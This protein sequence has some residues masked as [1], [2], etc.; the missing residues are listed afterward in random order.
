MSTSPELE[1]QNVA[2][3]GSVVASMTLL[4]RISGFVRDMM[5][6]NF[7]GAGAVTD[8][9]F[10]AFRI[11][12]FFRRLFAEG[13]FNQAFVPVLARYRDGSRSELVAFVRVMTGNLGLT[14]LIVVL[15][16]ILAAPGLVLVF[17]PGFWT[18]PE[19]FVLAR[20]MVE[21]TFP[22][23]GFI[24]MTAF[25]GAIL[26]THHRY[27]VPAFTPVLLNLSLI[28][29]MLFAAGA[30]AEPVF[31][32]AWGVL[33][34][35]VAQFL[36][37]LPALKTLGLIVAPQV[38][39]EHAGARRVGKLLVPAV[40]AA[41]V[42]QINALID[43]MLA[44][45]LLTGSISWL[46]YSDRLL[47]LPVGLVAV[48]LGTVLLPNLSRLDSEA[49]LTGF[50]ATLDWGLRVGVVFGLPAAVALYVL[51]LPLISTIFMHGATTPIDARMAALALQAFAVGL[52]PLVLVKVLAPG[53]FAREDTRTPFR[54]GLISVGTN[55]VLNLALFRVMGHVGLALATS[56]A[57]CV[58]AYL[59]WRGLDR[60]GRFRI[61]RLSVQTVLRC[62]AAVAAMAAVLLWTT[63]EDARW[64]EASVLGRTF[65]LL[66]SVAAGGLVYLA[67]IWLLGGRV[68]HLKHLA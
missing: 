51:A 33:F 10:V 35:G 18:R 28:G 44:S 53:Y 20:D 16:G 60:I 13:A 34:A 45:T 6:A 62:A 23:L 29:A 22:Y 58:N 30:F 54:I 66:R 17:A 56:A 43:T 5:L 7:F 52:V 40:F 59:L 65:W 26:N 4:S 32:L 19:Q 2:V 15:I 27:A 50:A 47:E 41:S 8:A 14:L 31:A 55:V 11:P 48:T 46:Y 39:L 9:F 49:N 25:A 42:N 61:G 57:A 3:Q 24:S 12:N 21:I 37:Q 36:F 1:Q 63:P 64:L 38:S 68:A 67:A